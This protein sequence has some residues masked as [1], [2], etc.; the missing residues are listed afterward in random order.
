MGDGRWASPPYQAKRTLQVLSKMFNMAEVRG[1]RPNGSNLCRHVPKY[2]GEKRE[3]YLVH[4]EL[5]RLGE[6]LRPDHTKDPHDADDHC[7]QA[8]K[9]IANFWSCHRAI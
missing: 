8:F 3:R 5:Q 6:A 2:R 7:L 1:L 4:H 9:Q